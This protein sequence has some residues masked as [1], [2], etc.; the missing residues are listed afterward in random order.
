[1]RDIG[2]YGL[3][4]TKGLISPTVRQAVGQTAKQVPR[5]GL[6]NTGK[7]KDDKRSK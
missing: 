2:R 6:I 7:K 1:M 4:K 3:L 5:Q